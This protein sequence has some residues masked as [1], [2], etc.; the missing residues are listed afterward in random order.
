MAMT[1]ASCVYPR[2]KISF[3]KKKTSA[4]NPINNMESTS[5]AFPE[6]N[7]PGLFRSPMSAP[8]KIP[9]ADAI[10]VAII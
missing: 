5:A 9:P 8:T 3:P 1:D 10:P 4:H 7:I 2:T 6:V